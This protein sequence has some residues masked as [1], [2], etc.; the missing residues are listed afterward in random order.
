[1][2]SDY[3]T[4]FDADRFAVVGRS[5]DQPFPLLSNRGLKQ[6]G[7]VVYAVD[8]S[9]AD[10]YGAGVIGCEYASIMACLDVKVNLVNTRDRL[11]EVN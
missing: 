9:V 7:K 11:L 4:F 3:E 1:M 6:R 8:P 2:P 5:A 10:I